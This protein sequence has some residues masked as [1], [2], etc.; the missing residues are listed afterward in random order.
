VARSSDSRSRLRRLNRRQR[1]KAHL[2]EF[3][4]MVF[5]LRVQFQPTLDEAGYDLLWS[6]LVDQ[7]EAHRLH[8]CGI[9]GGA[10][11]NRLQG[12]IGGVHHSPSNDDRN[13]IEQWL[14]A[15][16]EVISASAG[17]LVD[18]WYGWG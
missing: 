13:A 2:G 1:K 14:Q 16:P 7:I 4:E 5:D 6:A 10:D 9:W 12:M 11:D 17:P 18:G 3:V 8:F 15:R